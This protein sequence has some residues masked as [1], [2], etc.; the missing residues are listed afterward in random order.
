MNPFTLAK[1]Q[2]LAMTMTTNVYMSSTTKYVPG[3]MPSAKSKTP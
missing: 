3:S 2:D 1:K